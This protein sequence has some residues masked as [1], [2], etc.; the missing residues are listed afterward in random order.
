MYHSIPSH[1]RKL[2]ERMIIEYGEEIEQNKDKLKT[3]KDKQAFMMTLIQKDNF[4][5]F[6]IF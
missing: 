1:S 2:Q 4:K 5:N 6:S 3:E